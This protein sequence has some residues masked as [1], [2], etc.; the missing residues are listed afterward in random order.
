MQNFFYQKTLLKTEDLLFTS[1]ATNWVAYI[2]HFDTFIIF[3]LVK[4][5]ERAGWQ[6]NF[7]QEEAKPQA[8]SRLLERALYNTGPAEN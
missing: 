5:D 7:G 4:I 2:F 1:I 3:F 8:V 6:H